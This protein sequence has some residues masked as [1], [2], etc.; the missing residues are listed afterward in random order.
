MKVQSFGKCL[1]L[2]VM[3][4]IG[5]SMIG[6]LST[7]VGLP[8]ESHV[9]GIGR[10]WDIAAV[11]VLWGLLN[12]FE[13]VVIPTANDLGLKDEAEDRYDNQSLCAWFVTG[14]IGAMFGAAIGLVLAGMWMGLLW[15]RYINRLRATALVK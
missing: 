13:A 11:G 12:W 2:V 3:T 4:T 1:T 14:G 5:A 8:H 7:W 10:G 6:G 9:V 15:N